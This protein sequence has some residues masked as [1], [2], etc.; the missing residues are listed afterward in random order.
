[1]IPFRSNKNK[2]CTQEREHTPTVGKTNVDIPLQY[3]TFT[4]NRHRKSLLPILFAV[5]FCCCF[6]III[7]CVCMLIY[8]QLCMKALEEKLEAKVEAEVEKRLT[9][10]LETKFGKSQTLAHNAP[11]EYQYGQHSEEKQVEFTFIRP[12]FKDYIVYRSNI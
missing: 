8:F 1:M 5:I 3:F 12:R 9:E 7:A 10:I 11:N 2:D 4:K 6:I